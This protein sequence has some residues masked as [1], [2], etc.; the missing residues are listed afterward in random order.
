MQLNQD[1]EPPN[2]TECLELF[3]FT[4]YFLRSTD[5]LVRRVALSLAFD[6]PES[7]LEPRHYGGGIEINPEKDWIPELTAWVPPRMLSPDM[8][9]GW[10]SLNVEKTDTREALVKREGKPID[11]TG[12]DFGRGMNAEDIYFIAR[13]QGPAEHLLKLYRAYFE[14]I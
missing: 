13:I 1:T 5:L 11:P 9:Q 12:W 6:P 14:A 8:V 4:W 7:I 10:I 3:E 2:E